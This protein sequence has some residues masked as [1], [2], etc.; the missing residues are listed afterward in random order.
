MRLTQPRETYYL[1]ARYLLDFHN[2]YARAKYRG[3]WFFMD[4]EGNIISSNGYREAWDFENG[5][6]MVL[7]KGLF[8]FINE[9][10]GYKYEAN[11]GGFMLRLLSIDGNTKADD[12][13][14]DIGGGKYYDPWSK[15]VKNISDANL[16]S[17]W[18]A[19][20]CIKSPYRGLTYK[21]A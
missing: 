21:S 2:G 14:N 4:F 20:D 8:E 9:V 6:A 3:L 1:K 13:V 16:T 12:F 19:S 10:D 17:E 7:K 11:N 18:N 5:F 15:E